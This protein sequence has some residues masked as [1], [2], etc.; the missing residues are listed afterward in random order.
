MNYRQGLKGLL[1]SRFVQNHQNHQASNSLLLT[2]TRY[3]FF[4]FLKVCSCSLS[5][6]HSGWT[7][8]INY[9]PSVTRLV[10]LTVFSF[11]LS[12]IS[13]NFFCQ[14]IHFTRVCS[15]WFFLFPFICLS[16]FFSWLLLYV[17][18]SV[19]GRRMFYYHN[20]LT[21]LVHLDFSWMIFVFYS[22]NLL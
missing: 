21:C 6:L 22:K 1:I 19:V 8:C 16:Y 5:S 15:L 11:C 10:D 12:S 18:V 14:N 17:T 13:L 2:A 7:H 9:C 3:L 4:L 20:E